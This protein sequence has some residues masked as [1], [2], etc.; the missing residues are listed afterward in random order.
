MKTAPLPVWQIEYTQP[1]REP[2]RYARNLSINILCANVERAIEM[3]R[4]HDAESV[5]HVVRRVGGT[6]EALV[7]LDG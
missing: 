7:D 5:I 1:P 3:F 4:E 2:H 6:K